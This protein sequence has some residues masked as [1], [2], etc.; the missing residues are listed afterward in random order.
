MDGLYYIQGINGH[1]VLDAYSRHPVGRLIL[2]ISSDEMH[3]K[4]SCEQVRILY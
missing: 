3:Q 2:V 4:Y 1:G